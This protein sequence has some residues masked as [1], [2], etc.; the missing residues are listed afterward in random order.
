MGP[1][2]TPDDYDYFFYNFQSTLTE[3]E[4]I[5]VTSFLGMFFKR[6]LFKIYLYRFLC[7]KKLIYHYAHTLSPR[8]WFE[9]IWTSFGFSD[10][11]VSEKNFSNCFYVK[12]CHPVAIVAPLY[13]LWLWFKQTWTIISASTQVSQASLDDHYIW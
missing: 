6:I 10:R 3:V 11:F 13:T 12:I 9:Q 1:H 8:S 2:L 5:K 4:F 7:K